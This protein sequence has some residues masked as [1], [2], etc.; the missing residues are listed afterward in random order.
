MKMSLRIKWKLKKKPTNASS[1]SYHLLAPIEYNIPNSNKG[2]SGESLPMKPSRAEEHFTSNYVKLLQWKWV[3]MGAC[4]ACLIKLESSYN[5]TLQVVVYG[6]GD[7]LQALTIQL[8]LGKAFIKPVLF[9][10]RVS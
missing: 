7:L 6:C 9:V 5:G 3:N 1:V 8:F 4:K 2:L 10:P